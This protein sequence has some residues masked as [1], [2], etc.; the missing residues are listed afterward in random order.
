MAYARIAGMGE[1]YPSEVRSN[2]AWPAEFAATGRV[3]DRRELIDVN[4]AAADPADRRVVEHLQREAADPFL[5]TKRRRVASRE[6]TAADGETCAARAA[7]ADAGIDPMDV[8]VVMSSSV[9]PDRI[10]LANAPVVAHRLGARRAYGLGVDAAC[11]SP[12]VQLVQAAALIESGQARTVLMTHAH[13]I[14]R[15]FPMMHPASPNVGDGATALVMAAGS[16]KSLLASQMVSHGEYFDAVTWR[17]P[18]DD[19]PWWQEGPAFYLGS[20]DKET[21]QYLVVNT[22]RFGARTIR[23]AAEKAGLPLTRIGV[24]ASVQPRGWIPGAIAEALGLS[25]D[26]APQTFDELA[27]LGGT[28]MVSNLIEARRRG[29]L[30]PGTVVALYA[31]GAGFI[32]SAALL[33]WH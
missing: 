23:E 32:R 7:L 13:V 21:A 16:T 11:A 15:A 1:W 9:A 2:D 29:M 12:V 22:V 19:V 28:G 10:A 8:D 30:K 20:R 33:E 24:L 18:G 4:E 25:A 6:T 14:L 31:Q 3:S 5:G 26:I 17:R 27:H